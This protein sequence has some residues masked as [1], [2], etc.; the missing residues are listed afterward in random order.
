M[1][2]RPTVLV[3]D[4]ESDAVRSLITFLRDHDYDVVWARDGETAFHALDEARVDGMIAVLQGPRIDGLAVLRHAIARSPEL[5]AVMIAEPGDGGTGLLALQQGATDIQRPPLHPERLRIVLARGLAH[6]RLAARVDEM[7]ETL[8]ERFGL[9]HLVG[10]SPAFALVVEQVRHVASSRAPVLIQG[11][12]GTGKSLIARALHQAGARRDERFVWVSLGAVADEV[13]EQDLFGVEQGAGGSSARRGRLESADGGTLFLDRIDEAPPSV[14]IRLLR[15]LRDREF[16]RV[17]GEN[18]RR[19]DV[20]IVAATYRDLVIEAAAGR[21]RPDLLQRLGSVV[22]RVPPLR[23]RREDIPL[24]AETFLRDL[25][26]EHNRR[27]K[28]LTRGVLERLMRHAWPGNVRELRSTLEGMIVF[29]QG[30]RLL[31]LSDLPAGWKDAAADEDALHMSV[32]MTLE[33]AERRLLEATL[34]QTGF[35]KPRAASLLGIGLRTLY[36]KIQRYGIR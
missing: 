24:L 19:V 13:V 28:G 16:E 27:V 9:E 2:E 32:G 18:A 31:D 35:D 25:N 23:E 29:A 30:R 14:Q 3:V 20:R 7:R 36:R 11:E 34:R 10:L 12:T 4:R 17:F 6:Q 1:R 22:I 15:V 21:F 26:R 8:D 5:C 33:E